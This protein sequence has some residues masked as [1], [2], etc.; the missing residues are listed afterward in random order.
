[1]TTE[2]PL[3]LVVDDELQMR[4]LLRASL[5]SHGFRLVE[6]AA[7]NEAMALATSHNPE[8][9]LLDLCLP[10]GDGIALTRRLREW[11]RAWII[12]VSARGRESDRV[13]ALDAG[14]DDYVTKPFGVAEL[15]ARIRVGLRRGAQAAASGEPVIGSGPLRIDLARREVTVDERAVHLTP[16][17]YR[18]LVLLAQH[19]GKVVT[20]RMILDGVWGPGRTEQ[21]HYLRVFVAQLRRKLEADPA[22]PTLLLTEPGVGYRLSDQRSV[23]RPA[24]VS[25]AGADRP[26]RSARATRHMR[27]SSG[28]QN[29]SS[30][31]FDDTGARFPPTLAARTLGRRSRS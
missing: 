13:E 27:S 15:L 28:M 18:L 7:A 29:D 10:D 9:I 16:I 1:M 19:A 12:I 4:R 25:S 20:Q 5:V 17:E 3:V 21:T 22:R 26:W 11:S 31:G 2:S 8:V 6:A 14:A 23:P 30:T 24:Q